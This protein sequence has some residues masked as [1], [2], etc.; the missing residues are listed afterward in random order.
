VLSI[1]YTFTGYP[2]FAAKGVPRYFSGSATAILRDSLVLA[3]EKTG[4]LLIPLPR[5]LCWE[6]KDLQLDERRQRF[7][8]RDLE[9][10]L[11]GRDGY[12][13]EGLLYGNFMRRAGVPSPNHY[14]Q[15]SALRILDL[16]Q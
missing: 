2:A 10:F 5:P 12:L 6:L 4:A 15:I 14:E 11:R 7:D 1:P 8:M 13:I 9:R 3:D 16:P